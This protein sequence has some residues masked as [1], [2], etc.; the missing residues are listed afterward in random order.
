M[1]QS[2]PWTSCPFK[3]AIVD[4]S[5]RACDR[6]STWLRLCS[7][8]TQP[9]GMDPFL[10]ILCQLFDTKREARERATGS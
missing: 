6:H 3:N 7:N 9:H 10:E 5:E 4:I 2:C 1:N 8:V